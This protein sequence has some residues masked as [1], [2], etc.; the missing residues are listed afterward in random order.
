[1]SR[2]YSEIIEDAFISQEQLMFNILQKVGKKKGLQAFL[3][4]LRELDYKIANSNQE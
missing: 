1:M 3:D 2:D 4:A